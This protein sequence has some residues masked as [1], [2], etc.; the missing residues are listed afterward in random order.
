M[1]HWRFLARP[2]SSPR[3]PKCVNSSRAA[4]S[5]E[6]FGNY[7]GKRDNVGTLKRI[8]PE[9]VLFPV[10]LNGQRIRVPA[11]HVVGRL[12]VPGSMRYWDFLL[13]DHPAHPLT[14]GDDALAGQ[15]DNR[16]APA[17][18]RC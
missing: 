10:L 6:P 1:I 18:A 4:R 14:L 13:L 3:S 2:C 7:Y 5:R 12:G 17:A 8:A 9:P 15:A 11:V 16:P